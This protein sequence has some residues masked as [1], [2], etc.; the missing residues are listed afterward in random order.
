MSTRQKVLDFLMEAA[1]EPISGQFM[2]D[3]LACSRNA[4]WKA[5]E[6]LRSEGYQINQQGRKGY[7]LVD[8]VNH[9]ELTQLKQRLAT[10]WPELAITIE[11]K[12]NS[13]NDLAKIHATQ[14]P[15]VPGLFIA[16]EQTKGRG[17][18]GRSFVSSLDHGLY[19]SLVFNPKVD[20]LND[21]T[22][23]TTLAAAAMTKA[24]SHYTAS[25][26]EIKWVNDLFYQNKK[27][28]GILCESM[29]DIESH[30]VSSIIIGIG[31]NLAGNFE[32]ESEEIKQVAG[33][34][35]GDAIPPNFNYN[36]LLALFIEYF[37]EYEQNID[38]REHLDYYQERLLGL[39]QKVSYLQNGQTQSAIIRGIDK[40]GRLLVEHDN[41][42]IEALVGSEIH[43]SST[44]F[45]K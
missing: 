36:Q 17:R 3:H 26:L 38:K 15:M 4:I 20:S 7:V 16:T 5:I 21:I 23:Y 12:V 18:H 22:L 42:N 27:V 2:A 33:T 8:S 37:C 29:I 44:Q 14:S 11:E 25:P 31:L 9:L 32:Q 24:I 13:T 34:I 35:F 30:Q 19:L 6:Q 1:P 45:S 28:A 39:N 40:D 41:R 10:I 43:F